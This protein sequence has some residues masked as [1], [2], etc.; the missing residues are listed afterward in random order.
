MSDARER[1]R[2]ALNK[3]GL[4]L[5]R[6]ELDGVMRAFDEPKRKPADKPVADKRSYGKGKPAKADHDKKG[7]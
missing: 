5:T 1:V 2:H 3:H 6:G 4:S 7:S